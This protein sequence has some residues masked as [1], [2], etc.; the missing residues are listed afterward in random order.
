MS[1]SIE[2]LNKIQ[3]DLFASVDISEYAPT[4]IDGWMPVEFIEFFGRA[5]DTL[6]QERLDII[7][8]GTW[9]GLSANTMAQIVKSKEIRD[10][11]IT[12]IDTWLGSPEHMEGESASHGMTRAF[13][14]P[15]ILDTFAKNTKYFKNHDIIYPFPMASVQA[16]C[17]LDMK[18]YHA[19]IIY[20]DAGHEYDAV[21]LDIKVYWNLLK[22]GGFMIMDDWKWEGVNKAIKEFFQNMEYAVTG[23]QM[24]VR[25]TPTLHEEN[26]DTP[27][28]LPKF[29]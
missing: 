3:K 22:D 4:H 7:E 8:V 14:V 5:V 28:P 2:L 10:V 15:T 12:C 20:V 25:K 29:E 9:K 23:N 11:R 16:A 6:D 17:Y 21:L 26:T 18:K 13:G 24:I 19:D 1:H 27:N